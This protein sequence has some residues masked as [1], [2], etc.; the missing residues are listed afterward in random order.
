MSRLFLGHS[1]TIGSPTPLR[2]FRAP[3]TARRRCCPSTDSTPSPRSQVGRHAPSRSLPSADKMVIAENPTGLSITADRAIKHDEYHHPGRNRSLSRSIP[4]RIPNQ[5]KSNQIQNTSSKSLLHTPSSLSANY[6][7]QIPLAH[8]CPSIWIHNINYRMS[9]ARRGRI[10]R[11]GLARGGEICG[12]KTRGV[13]AEGPRGIRLGR[14]V[15]SLAWERRDGR[16]HSIHGGYVHRRWIV[17]MRTLID[18]D[19]RIQRRRV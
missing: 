5:T 2:L 6:P 18:G 12:A 10:G 9:S 11:D 1:E 19:R 3:P 7:S 16:S 13:V 15:V 17:R 4:L 8:P 14:R